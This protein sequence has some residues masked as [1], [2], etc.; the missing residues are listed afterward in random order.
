M[1]DTFTKHVINIPK[2]RLIGAEESQSKEWDWSTLDYRVGLAYN[3][4]C[5]K[6]DRCELV[7]CFYINLVDWR[8]E[9]AVAML[10]EV[11]ACARSLNKQRLVDAWW[12]QQDVG[13]YDEH[14]T[15]ELEQAGSTHE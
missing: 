5:T 11:E 13:R 3:K 12:G 9:N 6:L 2:S 10:P 1:Q 8:A 15:E 7:Y 4:L 14:D